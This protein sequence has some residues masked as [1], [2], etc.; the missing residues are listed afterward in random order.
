MQCESCGQEMNFLYDVSERE[1]LFV[2]WECECGHKLLER[3]P[4]LAEKVAAVAGDQ[5]TT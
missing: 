5:A 3:R 2:L 1:T 4:L